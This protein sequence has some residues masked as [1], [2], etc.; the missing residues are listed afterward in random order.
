MKLSCVLT[1][2]TVRHFPNAPLPTKRLASIDAALNERFSFQLALRADDDMKATVTAEGPEGW[3]VRVRRVGY[4]PLFHHNNPVLDNP[5][6]TD[7]LGQLPGL[8]PDPLFDEDTA[9]LTKDETNAFWFS[10]VPPKGAKPGKYRIA[11]KAQP[12][13]RWGEG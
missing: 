10:V 3:T 12:R 6:D 4:V 9:I 11:V 13:E 5:L 7:G 2:S 8:V 1:P